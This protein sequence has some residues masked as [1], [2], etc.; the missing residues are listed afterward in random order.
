MAVEKFPE[1]TF[2]INIIPPNDEQRLL[3]LKSYHIMGTPPEEV[4]NNMARIIAEDFELPIALISLVDRDQVFFKANVGMP[5]VTKV[6]RGLS[7]CSIAILS[8]EPT[9]FENAEQ[10]PCLLSNPLVHGDF[11][12]R[13]YAGAPIKSSDGFNLGTVCVVGKEERSF[14]AKEVARLER[15]AQLIMHEMEVRLAVKQK[16]EALDAHIKRRQQIVSHAVLIAQ[17]QASAAIARELH[18]NV[19]QI[20]TTVKLYNEMA[21][22]GLGEPRTL[23]EKSNGFLQQC[24]DEI[25]TL[26]KSLSAPTLGNISLE[27]SIIELINSV[28]LAKKVQINYLFGTLSDFVI[29]K[30]LHLAIYRIV[31]EQVNNILKHSGATYALVS[32]STDT[33]ELVLEMEDNGRGIDLSKKSLGNGIANMKIRAE[34]YNGTLNIISTPGMG[35]KLQVKF[36][37]QATMNKGCGLATLP[38]NP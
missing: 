10:A 18:D 38:N 5:G 9:V 17:E 3:K 26:S 28:N 27:D 16:T 4:F 7:L 36:P 25:R 12:L 6:H 37:K 13:F 32:I 22:D 23:L 14:S 21:I 20:L 11:G 29:N 2:G 33:E 19:N 15:Y 1:N 31:Q 8:D 34:N 24:I 35:C 30:D